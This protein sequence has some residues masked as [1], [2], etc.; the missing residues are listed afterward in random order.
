MCIWLLIN[1][2]D[3]KTSYSSNS[4][5][6]RDNYNNTN[7]NNYNSHKNDNNTLKY[8]SF[9]QLRKEII[10]SFLKED[11]SKWIKALIRLFEFITEDMLEFR[12]TLQQ[13][14]YKRY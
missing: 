12:W 6:S 3:F 10:K 2:I 7:K 13:F 4:S 1:S 8:Q 11:N 9:L 14:F 5:Y